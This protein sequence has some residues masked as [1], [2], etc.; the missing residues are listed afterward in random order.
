M[1]TPTI[2]RARPLPND[3]RERMQNLLNQAD[4]HWFQLHPDEHQRIRFYF[5][6][7]RV[8]DHCTPS[9]YIRVVRQPDGRLVRHFEQEGGEG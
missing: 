5:K 7:E 8:D 3:A 1:R 6:D 9:R 2:T 4:A